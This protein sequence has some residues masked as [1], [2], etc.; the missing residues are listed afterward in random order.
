MQHKCLMALNNWK[1]NRQYFREKLE[2]H[3]DSR[4]TYLLENAFECLLIHSAHS[5]ERKKQY[6]KADEFRSQTLS[7]KAF[8][9]LS[10]NKVCKKNQKSLI[11]EV[12]KMRRKIRFISWFNEVHDV[13]PSQR[14]ADDFYMRTKLLA[15]HKFAV[16]NRSNRAKSSLLKQLSV[17]YLPYMLKKRG[18]L[19]WRRVAERANFER[20]TIE[21]C[22]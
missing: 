18:V 11:S 6:A 4:Q 12:Q 15:M 9:T 22:R 8:E 16:E 3:R 7:L 10:I 21:T 2:A 1:E 13:M 17:E 5:K 14:K 20:D 19:K